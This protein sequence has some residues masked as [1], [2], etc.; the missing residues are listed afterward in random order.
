[1]GLYGGRREGSVVSFGERGR[2]QCGHQGEADF[3]PL[4]VVVV[5]GGGGGVVVVVVVL[6]V[7]VFGVTVVV[8]VAVV[9]V[10]DPVAVVVFS[11]IYIFQKST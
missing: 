11:F 4:V 5:G 3:A 6:V 8:G 1:M 2:H 9:I 10:A 7:A